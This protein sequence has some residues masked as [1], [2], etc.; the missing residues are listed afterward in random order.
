MTSVA[1]KLHIL[2][3]AS[4]SPE[5]LS[6]FL[7]ISPW[8][9][10]VQYSVPHWDIKRWREVKELSIID[11]L[12]C[13][14]CSK[15]NLTWQKNVEDFMTAQRRRPLRALDLFAGC[16]SFSF[17]MKNVAGV[18]TTHAIEISPSAAQTLKFVYYKFV[19]L[20]Y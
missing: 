14:D 13:F 18:K 19:F 3:K 2:H 15:E 17:A 16:G 20:L 11:V 9:F 7:Q 8:H 10:F 4:L 6:F 1:R 5:R 12:V